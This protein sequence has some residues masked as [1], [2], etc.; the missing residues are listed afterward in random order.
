MYEESPTPW[1][2]SPRARVIGAIVLFGFF[3]LVVLA[4]S[5][6]ILK[7]RRR[8]RSR[9]PWQRM[10]AIAAALEDEAVSAGRYPC[11]RSHRD[12][13][14]GITA[15][16]APEALRDGWG[17]P[18]IIL[19]GAQTYLIRSLGSDGIA[20]REYKEVRFDEDTGDSI[21]SDGAWLH[22]PG[23]IY[24]ES[25]F[26]PRV[27]DAF[28]ELAAC[29]PYTPGR[30]VVAGPPYECEYYL[31]LPSETAARAAAAEL[32]NLGFVAEVRR[33]ASGT[34]WLCRS[35]RKLESC[36]ESVR[37]LRRVEEAHGG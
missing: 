25:D 18:L 2:P 4:V 8:D 14:P 29:T 16:I 1:Q 31:Y 12:L 7:E 37:S 30:Q 6:S 22:Q 9:L 3:A 13:P 35:T 10:R 17:R 34:D 11:V 33:A 24:A 32:T 15:T 23:G 28:A 27:A 36:D 26:L 21:Y 20:D 19:A 5:Q